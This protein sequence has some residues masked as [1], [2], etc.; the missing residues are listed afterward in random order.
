V[1]VR[2]AGDRGLLALLL[3]A[4]QQQHLLVLL[5]GRKL[6]ALGLE[7][8]FRVRGGQVEHGGALQVDLRQG[9]L[10]GLLGVLHALL[11]HDLV[12][13]EP[14][15]DLALAVQ[16][17]L[18]DRGNGARPIRPTE[19]GVGAR[20]DGLSQP[21]D[22]DGDRTAGLVP[23]LRVSEQRRGRGRAIL[24]VRLPKGIRGG[25][26]LGGLGIV[27]R[28]PGED[29]LVLDLRRRGGVLRLDVAT[30]VSY[31]ARPAVPLIWS[32][33]SASLWAACSSC[34]LLSDLVLSLEKGD[35]SRFS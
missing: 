18:D 4:A 33:V 29:V 9:Q 6:D 26:H 31:C 30:A 3:L 11:G 5:D 8:L 12:V 28:R 16:V 27:H 25:G 32:W 17:H 2:Q 13:L 34:G 7:Q 15:D 22:R 14:A 35:S 24:I 19:G 20:G 10:A 1:L 21:G 23:P